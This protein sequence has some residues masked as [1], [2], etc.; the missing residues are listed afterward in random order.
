MRRLALIL[1]LFHLTILIFANN[2]VEAKYEVT[3][4]A[5]YSNFHNECPSSI[6]ISS[7]LCFDLRKLYEAE[8]KREKYSL[9][10]Q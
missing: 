1:I 2:E 5:K 6:E 3:F 7:N 4:Y 10:K 8:F 9:D